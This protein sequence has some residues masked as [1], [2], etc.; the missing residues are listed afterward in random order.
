MKI[1]IT[2]GMD[3]RSIKVIDAKCN[4][5]EDAMDKIN[6]WKDAEKHNSKSK[7]RI[8]HYDRVLFNNKDYRLVIDFGDYSHFI[9]V[10][11]NKKEWPSVEAW[12]NRPIDLEV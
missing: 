2:K 11:C 12:H 7:F 5:I 1:S 4:S 9:L 6:A 8:C 10:K 3:G